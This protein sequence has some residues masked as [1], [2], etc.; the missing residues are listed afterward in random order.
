MDAKLRLHMRAELK[1]LQKELG[2]TTIYVTHDQAEAMTMADRIAVMT[3]DVLFQL[4]TPEAIYKSPSTSFVAGFL[5][6]PPM[7]FID[8]TFV[9]KDGNSLLDAGAFTLSV[10]E[11]ADIIRQK[12]SS[13]ELKIGLRPEDIMVESTRPRTEAVEAEVYV[14]EPLGSKII[15]DL[16]VGQN[17][18]RARSPPDSTLSFG[19]KVWLTFRKNRMHIFDT[20]SENAIV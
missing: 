15:L 2:T 10:S 19:D 13:T 17:L 14:V 3:H 12:S 5:G 4:A 18:L 16:K 11:F 8:C 9:E 6:S 7:N 1:R 20:K